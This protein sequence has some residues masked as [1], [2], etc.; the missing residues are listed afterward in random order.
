MRRGG[1]VRQLDM[2]GGRTYRRKVRRRTRIPDCRRSQRRERE[3]NGEWVPMTVA[4]V[5][6]AAVAGWMAN[7]LVDWVGA[8]VLWAQST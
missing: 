7:E 5:C 8:L 2:W 3:M 1:Y 6:V 4:A